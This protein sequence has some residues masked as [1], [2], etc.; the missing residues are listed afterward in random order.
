M[1]RDK[2]LST[3]NRI[4]APTMSLLSCI[5]LIACAV[6]THG[7]VK[8]RQAAASGNFSCPVLFYLIVFAAV[9][10]YCSFFYNKE[11]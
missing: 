11:K 10:V 4:V 3:F 7:I 8:Y 5:F 2:S 6:Y 9:M 1:Y